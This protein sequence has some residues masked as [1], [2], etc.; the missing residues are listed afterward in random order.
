MEK[1]DTNTSTSAAAPK[2][3]LAVQV[4]GRTL[5]DGAIVANNPA[6]LA[7]LECRQ[8][9]PS[10]PLHCLVSLGSGRSTALE[11]EGDGKAP[12]AKEFG[13]KVTQKHWTPVE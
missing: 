9:W 8:L 6:A 12:S 1:T 5:Q 3:N 7:L 2:K 10:Y 4:E 13:I 11:E